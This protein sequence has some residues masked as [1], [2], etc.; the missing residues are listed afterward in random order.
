MTIPAEDMTTATPNRNVSSATFTVFS[1]T[2]IKDHVKNLRL[3]EVA[4]A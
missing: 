3:T 1:D 4:D 2:G